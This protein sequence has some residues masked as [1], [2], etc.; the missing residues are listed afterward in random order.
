MRSI[1]VTDDFFRAYEVYDCDEKQL[2]IRLFKRFFFRTVEARYG[3]LKAKSEEPP[4]ISAKIFCKELELNPKILNLFGV[5]TTFAQ[6]SLLS[7]VQY[8]HIMS[9]FYLQRELV[10]VRTDFLLRLLSLRQDPWVAL[11]D[12]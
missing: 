7:W 12:E 2:L 4:E 6:D 1:I 9:V 11:G 8:L 10:N 5:I 3:Y